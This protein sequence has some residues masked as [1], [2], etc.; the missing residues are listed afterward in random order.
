MTCHQGRSSGPAVDAAIAAAAPA[1]RR[2][3]QRDAQLPEHPLLPGRR[4]AVRRAGAR[5]ATSTRARSTTSASATS[6]ATTPASA[7]TTPTRR[8]SSSTP[9]PPATPA[10]PTSPARTQIRMMS[11]VGIDYDGDGNTTEG[12][13][14]E[15]VGLRDKLRHRHPDYGA[16]HDT[17]ICYARQ[18]L[19][20]LVRRQRRRRQL[21]GRRRRWPAN[22]FTSWTAAPAARHLQL[23]AGQQGPGRL[24]PQRQV[25]HRAALRRDHRRQRRA[26]RPRST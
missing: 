19:S 23:P 25:H 12:I 7:A 3:R 1:D 22:A 16:E 13:Y 11:S 4:H 5:A 9:A 8:R 24:R 14:D 15:L 21:L 20:L 18:Q 6:T 17:P 2:H 10:S 26:G